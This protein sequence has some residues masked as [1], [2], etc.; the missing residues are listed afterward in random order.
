[1]ISHSGMAVCGD[2]GFRN[3]VHPTNKM[4]VGER[5][6]VG[7]GAGL[8]VPKDAIRSFAYTCNLP[9]GVLTL[10]STTPAD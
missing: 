9:T 1:M 5:L 3:D 6:A 8:R 4:A 10:T 2:I 7:T